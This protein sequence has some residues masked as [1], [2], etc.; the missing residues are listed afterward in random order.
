MSG[1]NMMQIRRSENLPDIVIFEP[2]VHRDDRGWFFESYRRDVCGDNG[3]D[4]DFVQDNISFSREGVLRGMHYQL[5]RPQA[6]LVSVQDGEIFDVAVDIRRDSP[7]FGAWAGFTISADNHRQV[8]I[9][10]GFAHGFLVTGPHALV[11]YKCSDFYAPGEERGIRWNDPAIGIEWPVE[12][13]TVSPRDENL[14]L[15][16][17][18]PGDQL[19]GHSQAAFPGNI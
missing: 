15:L 1:E 8:F 10:E 17:D 6:K 3:A 12:P 16:A 9:P 2:K 4:R 5:A 7:T 19:P 11:T 14:P 13:S 18:I